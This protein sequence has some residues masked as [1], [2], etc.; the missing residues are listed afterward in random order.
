MESFLIK[1][2]PGLVRSFHPFTAPY[3]I[4]A[5]SPAATITAEKK[6]EKGIP[7]GALTAPHQKDDHIVNRY[8]ILTPAQLHHEIMLIHGE[9]LRQTQV[10]NAVANSVRDIAEDPLIN[11]QVEEHI[12]RNFAAIEDSIGAAALTEGPRGVD[13][14]E[15]TQRYAEERVM[16]FCESCHQE[17]SPHS[18]ASKSSSTIGNAGMPG[19]FRNVNRVDLVRDSI[20]GIAIMT[21]W[22]AML[23][24][25]FANRFTVGWAVQVLSTAW[26]SMVFSKI[27]LAV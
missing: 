12:L 17:V 5:A 18:H 1:K 8:E 21:V 4:N 24:K 15:S 25:H 26:K 27:N 23:S 19:N 2:I 20:K 6:E 14:F 11:S 13:Q 22:L 7:V 10:G 16:K 9:Q 3:S